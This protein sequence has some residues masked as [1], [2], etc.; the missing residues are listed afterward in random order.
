L[1]NYIYK[2]EKKFTK[3]QLGKKKKSIKK[4]SSDQPT[5]TREGGWE[6]FSG[7]SL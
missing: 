5:F 7:N 4:E 3:K 6:A 2:Q 1:T